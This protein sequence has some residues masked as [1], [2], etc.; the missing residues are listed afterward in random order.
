MGIAQQPRLCPPTLDRRARAAD[1]R[2]SSM[3]QDE[4]TRLSAAYRRFAA[5]EANGKSPLY[6]EL[7]RGVAAD[8]EILDFLLALPPPKRQPNLLF[9]AAR[10]LLGTPA[11]WA[12][13]RRSVTK[14][15]DALH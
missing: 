12:L 7:A 2:L 10:S 14:R 5:D 11:N 9:A 13:F 6:E 4:R 3:E 15:K 8:S 1:R